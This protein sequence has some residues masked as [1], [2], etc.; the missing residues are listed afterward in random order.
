M[1]M[2][3]YTRYHVDFSSKWTA[4]FGILMGLAFFLRIVYYFGLR[5][6]R[7]V[8]IIE[9]LTSAL[10]GICLCGGAVFFLNVLR[11]NA[12]GLYGMMGAVQCLLVFIVVCTTGNVGRIILAFVWYALTAVILLITVG[13]YLPGRLL[14]AVMFFAPVFVRFFFF[15]LGKIGIIRWVQELAVLCTLT[16]LGCFAMGLKSALNKK[17]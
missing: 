13:G 15:D 7:D 4:T 9:L 5:S 17:E 10:I 14:A 1:Q 6:L 11:R 12:P 16:A 8:G 2:K 3:K